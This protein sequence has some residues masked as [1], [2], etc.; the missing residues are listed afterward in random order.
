MQ[1][2]QDALRALFRTLDD[3]ELTFSHC[4][5]VLA[6]IQAQTPTNLKM[7]E[8]GA[9]ATWR[10]CVADRHKELDAAKAEAEGAA[11]KAEAE[12]AKASK[13]KAPKRKRVRR[14]KAQIEADRKKAEA[15]KAAANAITEAEA[16]TEEDDF[17]DFA[18]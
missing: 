16:E 5:A 11:K 10:Q 9:L 15:A 12:K 4:Q 8:E 1:R 2:Q 17:D 14:T 7:F 3:L 6:L 18:D 13:P